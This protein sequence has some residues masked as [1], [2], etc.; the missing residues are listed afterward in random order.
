MSKEVEMHAAGAPPDETTAV[1]QPAPVQTADEAPQTEPE[2]KRKRGRPRKTAAPENESGSEAKEIMTPQAM[3][4]AADEQDILT[5]EST[6]TVETEADKAK[7]NLL[8]LMESLRGKRILQGVIQGVESSRNGEPR[9]VVFKGEFK[10]MIPASLCVER[11]K[12]FRGMKPNDV[13]K[14]LI[15]KRL[16]AEVEY[17]VKG[18][19]PESGVVVAS[20]HEAMAIRRR[21]FYYGKDRK[22][23]NLIYEG[24]IAEA[25]VISVIRTG[26][27]VELFGVEYFIRL[28][29][30]G[31]QR[32]YDAMKHFSA[33]QRILVL[34][35]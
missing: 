13:L 17:I 31:Y 7:N 29:E 5:I 2:V 25:R 3:A 21:Q 22:G 27:F 8:D 28:E 11:P 26:A 16:G 9:A 23:N 30:L 20:R 4:M 1:A 19:D 10:V 35:C 15:T 6:R 24:R 14:Y 12:D 18:I 34:R 32:M 33:G